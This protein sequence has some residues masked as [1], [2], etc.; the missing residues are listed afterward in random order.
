MLPPA[1]IAAAVTT[2]A[3]AT[4]TPAAPAAIVVGFGSRSVVY[5]RKS[6]LK[7]N[8]EGNSPYHS[9]KRFVPGACNIGFH[10]LNQHRPTV[11]LA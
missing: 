8:F 3:A 6:N 10:R 11:A 5:R 7:A 9:F 1:V 2:P 4:T